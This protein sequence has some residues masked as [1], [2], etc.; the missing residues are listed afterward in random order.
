MTIIDILLVLLII[1]AAA[2]CVYLIISL[3]KINKSVE[4]LQKDVHDLI[5]KTIPVLENL[6]D[7]SEKVNKVASEAEG[8]W[9]DLNSAIDNAKK[10]VS[11]FSLKTTHI[12]RSENP[13]SSLIKNLSALVKGITAFWSEFSK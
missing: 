10:K 2:L 1:A 11:S 13:V 7:V 3:S 9:T 6:N 5:E 4:I 8:H 12:G